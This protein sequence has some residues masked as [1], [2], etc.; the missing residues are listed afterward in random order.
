[1]NICWIAPFVLYYLKTSEKISK[2]PATI[3]FTCRKGIP[4][5]AMAIFWS[6]GY[7]ILVNIFKKCSQLIVGINFVI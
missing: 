3:S 5:L 7:M 1:M 4:Y 2:F 6:A